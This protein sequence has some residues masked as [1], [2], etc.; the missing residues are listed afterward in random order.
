MDPPDALVRVPE[1]RKVPY[2]AAVASILVLGTAYGQRLRR[3][4][5][6]AT[7]VPEMLI[8]SRTAGMTRPQQASDLAW[9]RC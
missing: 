2:F 7:G 6:I 1:R 4:V 8:S 5:D 3:G 9:L